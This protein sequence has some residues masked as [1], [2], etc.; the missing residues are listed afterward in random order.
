MGYRFRGGGAGAD[1]T[2]LRSVQPWLSTA[3]AWCWGW[4]LPPA[5]DVWDGPWVA[6]RKLC[7]QVSG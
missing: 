3:V 1:N 6:P 2:G 7:T 5:A 4:F